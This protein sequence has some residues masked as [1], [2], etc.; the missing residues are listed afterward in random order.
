MSRQHFSYIF[1]IFGSGKESKGEKRNNASMCLRSTAWQLTA[2]RDIQ[3]T[4]YSKTNISPM[5]FLLYLVSVREATAYRR[6]SS[7]GVL[8]VRGTS[9]KHRPKR[10]VDGAWGKSAKALANGAGVGMVS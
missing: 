4:V 10:S 3:E 6:K 7:P 9:V 5:F 8:D 2:G 1:E